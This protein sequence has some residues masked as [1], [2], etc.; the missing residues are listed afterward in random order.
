VHQ[1][2]QAI[3]CAHQEQVFLQL[4]TGVVL[5]VLLPAQEILFF[6][7]DGTVGQTFRIV[8]REDDLDGAEERAVE[9]FGLVG[10]VLA[11]TVAN[12][13]AAVLQFQHAGCDAVHV[14]D[15]VGAAFVIAVEGDFLGDGEVVFLGL[16][17]VDHLDGFGGLARL[18]F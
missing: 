10:K 17:P 2:D 12:G 13:D 1:L 7:T 4:E 16:F 9:L 11:D 5:F 18:C 14:E 15:D 6:G 8:T 3:F